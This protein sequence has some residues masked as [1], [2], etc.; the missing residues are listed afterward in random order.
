M[1]QSRVA[2]ITGAYGY[3]GSRI[4]MRLDADGWRTIALVRAPRAG[5]AS[6]HQWSLGEPLSVQLA[7]GADAL[8]HCAYDMTL[9]SWDDIARV[10]IAGTNTLLQSASRHEIG[11]IL[12]L[13]SMSAYAGTGQ[14]YG[15][16]KLEI[17]DL[18]MQVHGT[19]VRP[20]LVYGPAAEGMV[21][22][23]RRLLKLPLTP[24]IAGSARQYPVLE[25]DFVQAIAEVLESP[26]WESEVFGIAQ[27]TAVPLRQILAHLARQDG[28]RCRLVPVPWR[29]VYLAMRLVELLR[30]SVAIRSDSL[31]GLVR[32]APFVP[33]SAAFPLLLDNLTVMENA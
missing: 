17:E 30:P 32:P 13:S 12:V 25:G 20:G 2:L 4:R 27:P 28:E 26:T 29:V 16:A 9:R 5:D 18:T 3:L 19:A 1:S 33:R 15:R 24:V 8:V 23:L 21:G 10:N 6:A 7:T 22:T 31:I 14:L 11:R